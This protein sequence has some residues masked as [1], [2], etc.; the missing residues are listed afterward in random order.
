MEVAKQSKLKFHGVEFINVNFNTTTPRSGELSI[1]IECIPKVFYP[2]DNKNNFRIVMDLHLSGEQCFE[3]KIIAIGSFE[4]DTEIDADLKKVFVNSNAPAI[5]FPYV[6]SFITTLTANLG[7][8]VGAL[9][10]PTQF[11]KGEMEEIKD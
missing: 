1:N 11:F 2:L 5:M 9:V 10:I 4:I 3:L 8:Y 6:R 7:S